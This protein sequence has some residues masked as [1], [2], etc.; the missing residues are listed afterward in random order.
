M[1]VQHSHK[2]FIAAILFILLLSGCGHQTSKSAPGTATVSLK[3]GAIVNGPIA[4][5]GCGKTSPI[6]PG[7]TTDTAI[8]S[9]GLQRTY[10]LHVP[11]GYSSDQMIP[12]VFDI[13]GHE[14]TALQ[15]ERYTQYS[16]LA[17]QQHFL[18]VYPQGLV[19]PDGKTGWAAYGQNAS[20]ANDVLYF[21][22][23]LTALQQQLCIDPHRI[24][25][26]GI[27]NGGGMTNLLACQMAGRIA[28][29]APIASAVYPIP[30]GCHPSRPVPYL[31]FH[32]TS[33]P[34]VE[35]NGNAT[36]HFLPV[37]QMMQ[38]WASRDGCT[39]GPT[40][41]FQ[42]DEVTG[43]QWTNCQGGVVV[44]HYRIDG[45]GHTWP[46]AVTAPA[47]GATTRTISATT[48]G[49]QFFQPYRLP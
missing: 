30:G 47:L 41:F 25:A 1:I 49:W 42:Q 3:S 20:T 23:L 27:S 17:D 39:S 38:D 44:Q 32:G 6:V 31:E 35:Y 19:G 9:N 48:L 33:D 2:W 43:L 5:T 21:S 40:T 45:G 8:T 26:T 18:V 46:D 34:L 15:I 37:M 11:T 36:V 13:H 29:F 7:S 28:A 12:L 22:D 24:Y 4:T 16:V 10:R 14:G